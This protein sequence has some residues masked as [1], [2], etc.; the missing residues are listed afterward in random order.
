MQIASYAKI[1]WS[2]RIIGRR[3]DGYHELET[4]FQSISL[5]DLLTIERADAI[6]LRCNDETIPTD[7]R[8]LAVRAAEV[9]QREC[10]AGPVSIVLDKRIPAGG[11]LGGGSSNAAAVLRAAD[12]LYSLHTSPDVLHEIA[13][14][15]G[16]DV[17]FFLVGGT[18]YATGRG[19]ELTALADVPQIPLLLLFPE[20]RVLT[21][22][23]FALVATSRCDAGTA[24]SNAI[25]M[26]RYVDALTHDFF[27]DDELLANDFEPPIFNVR[28]ALAALATRLADSG[29]RWSQMTGSGSTLVAAYADVADRD[30]ARESFKDVATAAA[31]TIGRDEVLAME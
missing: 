21:A 9:M 20:E 7:A 14:S 3:D 18:A 28:P 25:G 19:E 15:L 12:A 2:L 29:A 22:E 17:P 4:L 30:R 11:G 24:G 6:S 13:L 31:H 10:G 23:A 26:Q 16:S 27:P 5:H 8:N 1:N